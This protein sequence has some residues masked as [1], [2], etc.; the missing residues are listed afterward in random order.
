MLQK[1]GGHAFLLAKATDRQQFINHVSALAADTE[2]RHEIGISG[3][4]LY[5]QYFD[6]PIISAQ[7]LAHLHTNV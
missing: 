1:E 6:A 2:L 4:K 5:E 3:Q 7:V